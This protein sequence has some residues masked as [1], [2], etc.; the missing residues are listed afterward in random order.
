MAEPFQYNVADAR[1]NLRELDA[2]YFDNLENTDQVMLGD[3]EINLAW[4]ISTPDKVPTLRWF[5]ENYT[6]PTNADKQRSVVDPVVK[7]NPVIGIWRQVNVRDMKRTEQGQEFFY[8]ILTLRKGYIETLLDAEDELDWSEARV[9]QVRQLPAGTCTANPGGSTVSEFVICK[10]NNISPYKVEAIKTEIEGLDSSTFAPVIR[11]EAYGSNFHRLY[12][13]DN[14]ETDGSATISLLLAT[15]QF[16]LTGFQTW[17]T[18]KQTSVTYHWDVPRAIAQVLIDVEQGLGKSVVPSYNPTQGL[19]DIVVYVKDF[20]GASITGITLVDMCDYTMYGSL[21]WGV[22]DPDLYACP[23]Y[24]P[25]LVYYKD[26]SDNGDG[27]Y[28]VSIRTRK[29][30]FRNYPLR[31]SLESVMTERY[32]HLQ[33]NVTTEDV[34]DISSIPVGTIYRQSRNPNDDCSSTYD[35]SY[36]RGIEL[37]VDQT[38][39]ANTKFETDYEKTIRNTAS[40]QTASSAIGYIYRVNNSINDFDLYDI[41]MQ[42]R[43]AVNVDQSERRTSSSAFVNDYETIERNN[44][45]PISVADQTPGTIIVADNNLND[46][47][48]YDNVERKKVAV[49]VEEER[50]RTLSSSVAEQYSRNTKNDTA[51]ITTVDGVEARIYR[52]S[53]NLNDFKLYD[54]TEQVLM[55]KPIEL[56]Y[57]IYTRQGAGWK[58]VFRNLPNSTLQTRLADLPT[59]GST[60][61]SINDDSTYDGQMGYSPTNGGSSFANSVG[62][63]YWISKEYVYDATRKKVYTYWYPNYRLFFA[64]RQDAANAMHGQ[65]KCGEDSKPR[66]EHGLWEAQYATAPTVTATTTSLFN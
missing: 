24:A 37:T 9:E 34:P 17:A 2:F 49:K 21:Y 4:K 26:I 40:V 64:I 13:A 60:S 16:T 46:F 5:L 50:L 58:R 61:I 7:G 33:M 29:A 31:Q 38:A 45:A 30:R 19:V 11:G 27:S 52:V 18:H 3:S 25:G 22:S 10:W 42:T 15:P 20:S 28:D 23:S 56:Y 62:N 51:P 65:H 32:E 66:Y 14:I 63:A 57:P 1:D 41:T 43:K 53:Y 8:V 59:D 6:W 39:I 55:S 54:S 35:T 36:D 47:G 48:L 44:A 12:V